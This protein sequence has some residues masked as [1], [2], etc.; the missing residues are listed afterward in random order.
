MKLK[1]KI[2]GSEEGDD[3]ETV[4]LEMEIPPDLEKDVR[5]LGVL[6]CGLLYKAG[7]SIEDPTEWG[8]SLDS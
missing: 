3:Y 4:T 7:Y 5:L 6:S 1:V 2:W 8:W